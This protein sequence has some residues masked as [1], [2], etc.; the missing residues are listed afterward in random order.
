M[1]GGPAGGAGEGN[2]GDSS[3]WRVTLPGKKL[4]AA[5]TG[6]GE[7]AVRGGLRVTADANGTNGATGTNVTWNRGGSSSRSTAP[8]RAT[9]PRRTGGAAAGAVVLIEGLGF[10]PRRGLVEGPAHR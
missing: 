1:A 4:G 10:I 3:H 2:K 5:W 6:T 9:F 7:R 8:A